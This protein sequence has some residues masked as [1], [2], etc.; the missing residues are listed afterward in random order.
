MGGVNAWPGLP[1]CRWLKSNS[2]A[3]PPSAGAAKWSLQGVDFA[4]P[5]QHCARI[6]QSI[7]LHKYLANNDLFVVILPK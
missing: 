2:Y 5:S 4:Q 6:A 3:I 7:F 1:A